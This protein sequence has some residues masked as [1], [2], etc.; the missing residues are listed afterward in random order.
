MYEDPIDKPPLNED[1]LAHYGIKGMKWGKHKREEKT[2]RTAPK[3]KPAPSLPSNVS[4]DDAYFLAQQYLAASKKGPKVSQ[5][6][7]E[8]NLKANQIKS[9]QKLEPSVSKEEEAKS[10]LTPEQ[11]AKLKKAAIG[12]A[13]VGGLVAVAYLNQQNKNSKLPTLGS[14]ALFP[15]AGTKSKHAPVKSFAEQMAAHEAEKNAFVQKL[16]GMAGQS[17]DKHDY[18]KA[19]SHSKG[20]SWGYGKYIQESSFQQKGFELPAGH[21]FHRISMAAEKTFKNGG[22]YATASTEDFNRYVAAFRQEKGGAALHHINF[23]AKAPMK[24]PSLVETLQTMRETLAEQ[25][26]EHPDQVPHEMVLSTYHQL[27]G[28]SWSN[29]DKTTAS[30]FS[31]MM[32]KG[33]HALVDEMDA[34]VIGEKPLV[35]FDH[36]VLS[37]KVAKPLT[38]EAIKAAED[39]LTEITNRKL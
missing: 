31:N 22:T 23:T 26:N 37:E 13:V 12:A 3:A 19:V 11:K 35:I 14:E 4:G 38:K 18:A 39:A 2:G 5:K 1:T 27:S 8:A 9:H 6:Q 25:F 10:K 17:I 20:V 30:F 24:V 36:S 34:G 21:T 16:G 7:A 29:E 33:Y 28:G 15:L 32:K